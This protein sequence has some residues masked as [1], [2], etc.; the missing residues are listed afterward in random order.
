MRKVL[1]STLF[2]CSYA[3]LNSNPTRII[4]KKYDEKEISVYETRNIV[5]EESPAILYFTGLNS[6]IPS[7]VY[8]DFL[9][10]LNVYNFTTYGATNNLYTNEEIIDDILD[11]HPNLTIVAHSSGCITAAKTI[12]KNTNVKNIIFLDPV[13]NSFLS[14]NKKKPNLNHVKKIMVINAKKSYDW[15]WGEN[16][17]KIPFIP[18]FKMSSDSIKIKNPKIT[19]LHAEDYGHTDILDK[20]WSEYMHNSLSKGTDNR[21]N[22]NL[23]KYRTWLAEN[24][25][26][27]VYES[28]N[29]TVNELPIFKPIEKYEW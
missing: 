19:I 15:E 29:E 9:K 6:V 14:E 26:N 20:P 16:G 2:L 23:K 28:K 11:V 1:L 4:K 13:D 3:F 21:S 24:I 10:Q 12:D 17:F 22:R 7:F 8:S 27:F 25:A 18:A 5:N